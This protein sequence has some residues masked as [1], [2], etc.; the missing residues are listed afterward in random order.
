MKKAVIILAAGKGV[1]M[2]SRLPKALCKLSGRPMVDFMVDVA[3]SIKAEKIVV[4]GGYRLDLIKKHFKNS[5]IEIAYQKRLLGSADAVKSAKSKLKDFNGEVIVL[6]ADTPLIEP[7]TIKALLSKHK[8][9]KSHATILSVKVDDAKEYGR[10]VRDNSGNICSIIEH[11]DIKNTQYDIR[12]TQYEIN[13]GAYCF[14]SKKLFEGLN[15]IKLNKKREEFYLTDI[16]DY[17]Y[18]SEYNINSFVTKDPD[19][20][21]GINRRRELIAAENILRE[22]TIDKLLNKGVTVIDPANTYIQHGAKIGRDSIIFPFVVIEKDVI[23]GKASKIGPFAHLRT[24]TV[25]SD[26]VSVGNFVEIVRSKVG[27]AS[28]VKHHSYLGDTQVA[29]KVNIGAGTITANYDGKNKNKT[30]ISKGAFIGSGTTIVAP[31]KIGK[32]A[33]TGAGC[34]VVKGKDVP[35]NSVVC[36]V[37]AKPIKRK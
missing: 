21:L 4:V 25:L 14:N 5:N 12:S 8:K 10:I 33:I 20:A 36:G 32:N 15:R 19:Q 3:K 29:N 27:K 34:V 28:R 17:F 30:I 6:Y 37:P 16:V 22:R 13:A 2:K 9:T 31:V 24:G 23:V 11:A 1:R 35:A 26:D 7:A 18:K